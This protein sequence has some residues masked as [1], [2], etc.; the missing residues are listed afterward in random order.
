M[1]I[2][3]IIPEWCA[4]VFSSFMLVMVILDIYRTYLQLTLRK[5]I[6]PTNPDPEDGG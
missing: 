2:T 1:E 4:W 6:A 3:L 5:H